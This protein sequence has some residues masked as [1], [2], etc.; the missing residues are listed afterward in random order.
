MLFNVK[1]SDGHTEA[2]EYQDLASAKQDLLGEDYVSVTPAGGG[3][4]SVPSSSSKAVQKKASQPSSS[5]V[6]PS[7]SSSV[8]EAEKLA[9]KVSGGAVSDSTPS[10]GNI[11]S[12]SAG[13][14]A[15]EQ[16]L[17]HKFERMPESDAM[18]KSSIANTMLTTLKGLYKGDWDEL[19]INVSEMGG[20]RKPSSMNSEQ[21][22][23]VSALRSVLDFQKNPTNDALTVLLAKA[24]DNR[25][26]DLGMKNAQVANFTPSSMPT[27][28]QAK[29]AF[30]PNLS[31]R[32]A[33]NEG[34]LSQGVG[35]AHDLLTIP[36]RFATAVGEEILPTK[37]DV[38]FV[39]RMA[40]PEPYSTPQENAI[41]FT[42]AS[43]LPGITLDKLGT[44][45]I[46]HIAAPTGRL[47]GD[48]RFGRLFRNATGTPTPTEAVMA[49]M[50]TGVHR[51]FAQA[52]P[53]GVARGMAYSAEPAA[54]LATN[55]DIT[56]PQATPQ[57]ALTLA[58]GGLM[59]GSLAGLGL[60]GNRLANSKSSL[61]DW[62]AELSGGNVSP[63]YLRSIANQQPLSSL[64]S[65]DQA[66]ASMQTAAG[67][68]MAADATAFEP[69]AAQQARID[70]LNTM[71]VTEPTHIP[72]SFEMPA[73]AKKNYAVAAAY[74]DVAGK[75]QSRL[76][77]IAAQTKRNT[78][79][80]S[81][82]EQYLGI[83][84]NTADY[85]L[86][87]GVDREFFDMLL[88]Q[89]GEHLKKTRYENT[90]NY[91][92]AVSPLLADFLVMG[93][94]DMSPAEKQ[95]LSALSAAVAPVP[96]KELEKAN[97]QHVTLAGAM[98]A[99]KD[100]GTDGGSSLAAAGLRR[101]DPLLSSSAEDMAA[102]QTVWD[103]AQL[104]G[105]RPEDW[106]WYVDA[107]MRAARSRSKNPDGTNVLGNGIQEAAASGVIRGAKGL[108]K[109]AAK[110]S[111]Y[112][113][114]STL[115]LGELG[116]G[117]VFPYLNQLPQVQYGR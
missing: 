28:D 75:I 94:K 76:E 73:S 46:P 4:S 20:T 22:Q 78:W 107:V 17:L 54:V 65:Q 115:V 108:L 32:Q 63:S 97:A 18:A 39:Q 93:E 19:L 67:R 102:Q 71:G 95:T 92:T 35:A 58:L 77:S 106:S 79:D 30:F 68:L 81:I 7:S 49:P 109:G 87:S 8:S 117:Y 40:R 60:L 43:I 110:S 47:L 2:L 84:K 61:S 13:V 111:A 62:G 72:F 23:F 70:A 24:A 104:A 37:G 83:A 16:T 88:G 105:V 48:T 53:Q 52:A 14:P 96:P 34:T 45:A 38:G 31:L 9:D 98:Q 112:N 10:F 1:F 114:P 101:L 25:F 116:N 26:I 50:G 44:W 91:E 74:T 57:A 42:A 86:T 55:P 99:L 33:T 90:S 5:S 82:V 69:L 103:A 12:N 59:G 41:D 3:S 27:V 100:W 66:L 85:K 56:S 11:E 36:S 21:Q 29:H 113:A 51:T 80:P 89:L 64:G 15:L 6:A